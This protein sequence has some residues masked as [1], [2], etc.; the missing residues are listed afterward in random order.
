MSPED[1]RLIQNLMYADAV[2]FEEI[3]IKTSLKRELCWAVS[4]RI[5]KTYLDDISQNPKYW[6]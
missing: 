4:E 5:A 2:M 6:L 1:E 3:D